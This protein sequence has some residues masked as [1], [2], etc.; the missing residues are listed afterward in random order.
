MS[1][2]DRRS[3]EAQEYRRRYKDKRWCGPNGVRARQLAAH[4]LCAMC[5]A[6]GRT[7]PATVCDHVDPD[8]KRTEEG[9]FAGPFAS[10]CKPHHDSTKQSEER[11][12]HVV[13]CDTTG[14][15]RDQLHPWN[16]ASRMLQR[17]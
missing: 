7:T 5:E 3:P 8:S 16:K 11:R 10:L 1:R 9:F 13:G 6:A 17:P 2:D 14:R 12:G 4:P 15:P